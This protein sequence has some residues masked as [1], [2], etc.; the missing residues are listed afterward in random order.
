MLPVAFGYE[1]YVCELAITSG[2]H[3]AVTVSE[4]ML[5]KHKTESIKTHDRQTHTQIAPV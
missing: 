4:S 3:E 1:C 5:T 2:P